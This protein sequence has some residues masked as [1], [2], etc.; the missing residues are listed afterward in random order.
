MEPRWG[1]RLGQGMTGMVATEWGRWMARRE[2]GRRMAQ[3]TRPLRADSAVKAAAAVGSGGCSQQADE[4]GRPHA[5][6]C[7][8]PIA[9]QELGVR[10]DTLGRTPYPQYY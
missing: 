3:R 9:A 2:W 1:A 6:V 4:L 7:F 8:G 10:T 5:R